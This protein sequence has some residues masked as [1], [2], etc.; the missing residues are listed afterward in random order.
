[1]DSEHVVRKCNKD[2]R[3]EDRLQRGL[4]F[5]PCGR[6]PQ[7]LDRRAAQ[8]EAPPPF[9]HGCRFQHLRCRCRMSA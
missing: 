4:C 7:D 8:G 5:H 2:L 1:M 6:V 9:P 3:S